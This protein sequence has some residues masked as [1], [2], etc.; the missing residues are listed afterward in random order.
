LLWLA[1]PG[2][3]KYGARI[4]EYRRQRAWRM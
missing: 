3:Q 4:A 1:M 2:T